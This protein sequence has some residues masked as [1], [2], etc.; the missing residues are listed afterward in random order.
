M[1]QNRT[2][3]W[4]TLLKVTRMNP[5]NVFTRRRALGFLGAA[6]T[7][8]LAAC[9]DST[10]SAV[11]TT[12]PTLDSAATT[13]PTTSAVAGVA[14]QCDT[15]P[16]ETAGP[17]PGDGSNGPD[18]RSVDGVVRRDIR[19]SIGSASATAEGTPLTFTLQMRNAANGCV[20]YPGAAV[21][22]WHC[23]RDGNYSMYSSP[24]TAE[25]Y[26]RGIQEADANGNVT[27]DSIFPGCYSG[28][29]PH[30]HFEVFASL[31]DAVGGAAPIATSQLAFP[32][33]ACADAY[34]AAGYDGS[35]SNLSRL[36]LDSDMVFADGGSNQIA[37]MSGDT[38]TGFTAVL[39][40]VV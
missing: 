24:I 14:A 37:T 6:G 29:W 2:G 31:A 39:D 10:S 19:T 18:I 21:Y 36:S 4:P 1:Q 27:F 13:A 30:I 35:A 8:I 15:I 28:R 20:A 3:R 34:A 16:E 25:N 5:S 22:A 32:A 40:V 23:D 12:V 33:D 9:S 7:A 11:T 17:F 26:L 38:A